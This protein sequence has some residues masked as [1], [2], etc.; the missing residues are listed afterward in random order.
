MDIMLRVAKNI[1]L[2]SYILWFGMNWFMKCEYKNV[3]IYLRI[4]KNLAKQATEFVCG[5]KHS[6][7]LNGVLLV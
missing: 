1:P 5:N 2:A 3:I 4:E 6:G 7:T